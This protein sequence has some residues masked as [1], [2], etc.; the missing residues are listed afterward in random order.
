MQSPRTSKV[1][2]L[3][4]TSPVFIFLLT[5]SGVLASTSP[6]IVTVASLCTSL[7]KS[8]SSLISCTIPVSSLKVTNIKLPKFLILLTQP[9]NLISLPIYEES[10]SPQ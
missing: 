5:I 1:L 2:T 4:S 7:N 10:T 6:V 3:T 9:A 8:P